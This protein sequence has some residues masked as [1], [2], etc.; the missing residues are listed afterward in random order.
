MDDVASPS[1]GNHQRK[2]SEMK[3]RKV[4]LC[5]DKPELSKGDSSKTSKYIG[6]VKNPRMETSN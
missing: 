4:N 2:S 6:I 3:V 1:P 5:V